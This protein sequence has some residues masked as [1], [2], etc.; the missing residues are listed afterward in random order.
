MTNLFDDNPPITPI[1]LN[2]RP[3]SVSSIRKNSNRIFQSLESN[4]YKIEKKNSFFSPSQTFYNQTKPSDIHPLDFYTQGKIPSNIVYSTKEF[5]KAIKSTS[6]DI[7]TRNSLSIHTKKFNDLNSYKNLSNLNEQNIS[8]N[9]YMDPVRM[10]ITCEKYNIP[11]NATN[12]EIYRLMK[13]KY[14]AR[15][16]HSAITQGKCLTKAEFIRQKE[17]IVK[18]DI[19]NLGQK[20]NSIKENNKMEEEEEKRINKSKSAKAGLIFKDPND[21]TKQILKDNYLYFDKN[22]TNIIKQRKWLFEGKG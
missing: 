21:Y 1:T 8:E 13:E 15:D 18:K 12:K 4:T 22:N 3:Y 11:K 14:Y 2:Q 5:N 6:N 17:R 16:I 19:L 7:I 20:R 9:N 10:Y